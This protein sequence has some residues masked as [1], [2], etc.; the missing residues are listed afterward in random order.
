MNEVQF[1]RKFLS[2]ELGETNFPEARGFNEKERVLPIPELHPLVVHIDGAHDVE[3][4]VSAFLEKIFPI[5]RPILVDVA[6]SHLS[7]GGTRKQDD[8]RKGAEVIDEVGNVFGSN[9]F[10][11]LKGDCQIV[12]LSNV[13]FF[14][15]IS[16]RELFRVNAKLRTVHIIAVESVDLF[17]SQFFRGFQPRPDATAKIRYRKNFDKLEER[18]EYY[19][20]RTVGS[21]RLL[22]IKIGIVEIFFH[23]Q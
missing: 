19:L 13:D 1:V 12:F 5:T 7:G 9:V 4:G 14:A 22:E 20:R 8:V 15:D 16:A 3:H 21:V 23:S 17:Y 2:F 6:D 11:Y 10:R 18:R